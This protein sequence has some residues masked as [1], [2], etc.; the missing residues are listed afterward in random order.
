MPRAS[1][2]TAEALDS[3]EAGGGPGIRK[4]KIAVYELLAIVAGV[5]AALVAQR[6][7]SPRSKIAALVGGGIVFG[8]L[9]SFVGG[10]LFESWAYLVFDVAEVLVAGLV[11]TVLVS[12]WQ[13]GSV[14]YPND[15]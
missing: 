7:D 12:W 1:C 3:G 11:T 9:V 4:E 6:I 2:E 5:L 13:R 14:R 10:E 8:A 15:R